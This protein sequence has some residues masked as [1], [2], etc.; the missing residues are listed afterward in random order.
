MYH[1][2]TRSLS[3]L[4]MNLLSLLLH[5][6]TSDGTIFMFYPGVRRETP[7][8]GDRLDVAVG[9]TGSE[10]PADSVF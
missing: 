6:I 4:V 2:V 1:V 7:T 8:K 3:H 10:D 9:L 5:V